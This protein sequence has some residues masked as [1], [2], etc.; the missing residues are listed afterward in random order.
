MNAKEIIQAF[1]Q[2]E[3]KILRNIDKDACE[4]AVE[5][6]I[7]GGKKTLRELVDLI[8]EPGRGVDVQARHALHA[9]AIRVGGPGKTKARKAFSASLAETLSDDRPNAVKGFILRQLQVCAGPE[10]GGKIAPFLTNPEDHLYEYAAQALEAMGPST[11]S[12]FRKAYPKASGPPRLTILQGLGVHRDDDS[13]EVFRKAA[14]AKDLETR[15]AGLWGLMRIA[16]EQDADLLLAQSAKEKG[17][18]RIKA[19]AYCMELAESLSNKG[20]KKEARAIY[21]EIRKTR[22]ADQEDYLRESADRELARLK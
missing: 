20:R 15:L 17:W 1:P 2:P 10:E 16:S 19:T 18:G 3:G 8:V 9:T 11:V 22:K 21:E 5:Q 14:K 13:R 12:H 7:A 4:K 6:I